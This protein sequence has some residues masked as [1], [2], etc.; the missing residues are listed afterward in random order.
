MEPISFG[1]MM[2]TA[3]TGLGA[4]FSAFY[5]RQARKDA[6]TI[7]LLHP[8]R[9]VLR[10]L[11]ASSQYLTDAMKGHSQS[12]EATAAL[13]EAVAVFGDNED[14]VDKLKVLKR[15]LAVGTNLL[16]LLRAMA[17]AAEVKLDA[18]DDE[19]LLTP[20]TNTPA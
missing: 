20:F 2:F 15:N 11:V 10:R 6:R 7:Y 3:L 14:V 4:A 9:D 16:P 1:T 5:A 12:V 18:Y 19:F 8:K 13:N 17:L